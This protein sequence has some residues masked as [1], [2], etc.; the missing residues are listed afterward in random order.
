[1]PLPVVGEQYR[2]AYFRNVGVFRSCLCVI[3]LANVTTMDLWELWVMKEY[4]KGNSWNKLFNFRIPDQPGE[5]IHYVK[6]ILVTK[7]CT[8]LEIHT[9]S[10][11]EAKLVRSYH[12]EEMIEEV[13]RDRYRI[14]MI[15]YEESLLWLE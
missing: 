6:P 1:M 10:G 5:R 3:G 15:G 9:K 12:K 13:H 7:T 2:G 4:D 8:F 11:R 14:G